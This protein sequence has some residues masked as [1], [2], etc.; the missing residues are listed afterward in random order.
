MKPPGGAGDGG[1]TYGSGQADGRRRLFGR[2]VRLSVA[3]DGAPRVSPKTSRG[4]AAGSAY[5]FRTSDGGATHGR[6]AKLTAP[7]YGGRL[8]GTRR[9]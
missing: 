3:I 1:A 7:A 4:S 6:V 5:V 9:R 8:L 2:Q